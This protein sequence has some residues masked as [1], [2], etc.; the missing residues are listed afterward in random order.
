[1]SQKR[2]CKQSPPEFKEE[3][4]AL[5]TEQAY[6]VPEAAKSLGIATHLLYRWKERT[7]NRSVSRSQQKRSWRN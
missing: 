5:V 2:S 3:G 4:I 7:S 6:S 1:M